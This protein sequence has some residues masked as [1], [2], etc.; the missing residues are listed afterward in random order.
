MGAGELGTCKEFERWRMKMDKNYVETT[1]PRCLQRVRFAI[2]PAELY[3]ATP[4]TMSAT[5]A[6]QAE[7]IRKQAARIEQMVKALEWY[8]ARSNY[9]SDGET[10]WGREIAEDAGQRAREALKDV[11]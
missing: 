1:C 2:K 9:D 6:E 11:D 5:I 10:A 8:A 7:T 3:E 4:T